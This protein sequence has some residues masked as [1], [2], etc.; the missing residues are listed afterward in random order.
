MLPRLAIIGG[1]RFGTMH[2]RAA[3]QARRRG[4]LELVGLADLD[5]AV[6]DRQGKRFGV[7]PFA[8]HAELLAETHPNAVAVVTP[9][10]LHRQ[11]VLDSLAAG[12]HVLV[13][14]PMATTV[15]DARAMHD[16]ARDA[17]RLLQVDFHKRYDPYHRQ[18]RQAIRD[19]R[20]G[21]PQYAYAWV[22]NQ[23]VVPTEMLRPWSAQSSP[24]WFLG[25]HM[26]DLLRWLMGGEAVQ[27]TASGVKRVLAGMGIDTWDS[28]SARVE[29]DT[30]A[31]FTVDSSWV[32]PRTF[33]SVIDQGLRFVGDQGSVEIDSQDRGHRACTPDGMQTLNLG[34]FE[35]VT[36]REGAPVYRGYGIEAIDHFY[37]NVAY[38][39]NG[40]ALADLAG[41]YPDSADGLAVTAIAVAAHA[42]A[43]EKVSGTFF[44]EGS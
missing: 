36:D 26:V 1:G 10:P 8:T 43:Q 19:G 31:F 6:R 5:P 33:E 27:V 41:A 18:L 37:R 32:L 15:E 28:L 25:V 40:G 2:L 13:E 17:G 3:A 44:K 4:Q 20:F 14:K 29:L 9:D 16:A 35:E 23:I 7:R 12:A 21:R 39:L 42:S 24:F 30:G 11:I 38:L 22:E 34:F